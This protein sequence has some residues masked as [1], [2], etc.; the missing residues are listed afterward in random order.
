M[1]HTYSV[2][3][4]VVLHVGYR[5]AAAG[6]AVRHQQL[7]HGGAQEAQSTPTEQTRR[8]SEEVGGV[9]SAAEH[10]DE[11]REE[12]VAWAHSTDLC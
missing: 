7:R 9:E 10:D 6:G 4:L 8:Q 1:G 12:G 11:G 2:L 5:E 3:A